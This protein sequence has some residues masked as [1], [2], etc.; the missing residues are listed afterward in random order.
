VID[1]DGEVWRHTLAAGGRTSEAFGTELTRLQKRIVRRLGIPKA[2]SER[3]GPPEKTPQDRRRDVREIGWAIN[4]ILESIG[5][6][7]TMRK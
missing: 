4:P 2:E 3:F 6:N 7:R 1:L 5:E